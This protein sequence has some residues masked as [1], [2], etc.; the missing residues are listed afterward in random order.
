MSSL[1][2]FCSQQL[3]DEQALQ[4]KTALKEFDQ[5]INNRTF[6]FLFIQTLEEQ[7]TFMMQDKTSV[8]SLLMVILQSKMDYCTSVIKVLLGKLIE[9]HVESN[10][11][12]LLMRR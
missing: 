7:P 10:R 4:I 11:A 6:L 3:P 9:K 2:I 12:K 5:L 1:L 8:A